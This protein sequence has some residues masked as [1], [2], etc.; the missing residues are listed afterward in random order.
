MAKKGTAIARLPDDRTLMTIENVVA[1]CNLAEVQSFG[2]VKQALVMAS[3]IRRLDELITTEMMTN[4]MALQGT[5]IGFKT[6]KD[7]EGGYSVDIVKRCFIE[8]TL[9]GARPV[10]N[11]WNIISAQP[12]I[13]K[14]GFSRL[15]RDFPGLNNLHLMPNVPVTK[16][17]GA[18]VPYRATWTLHGDPQSLDR[19]ERDGNDQRIPV[20]VNSG[21]GTDAIIG[22][23][24]RKMLA[25]IYGVLT[26]THEAVPEGEVELLDAP[27]P[28]RVGRSSATDQVGALTGGETPELKGQVVDK[29]KEAPAAISAREWQQR[30]LEAK[31]VESLN[32]VGQ[33]IKD[34]AELSD[35]HRGDLREFFGIRMEEIQG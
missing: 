25:A 23:A 1:E 20:R 3:G 28:K 34:C 31:D 8:A 6:D 24:T 32:D 13:T 2:Q 21:M 5:S 35:D 26:G 17:G 30:I 18:L 7:K 9:R 22:K 4:V 19:V 10:N 14:N 16:P 15:V 27:A 33:G 29:A 11:E 12:Y